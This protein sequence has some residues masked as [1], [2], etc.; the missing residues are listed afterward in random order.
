MNGSS[1]K[2]PSTMFQFNGLASNG[3]QELTYDLSYQPK[4]CC[5]AQSIVAH[6]GE[7]MCKAKQKNSEHIYTID[8]P[9]AITFMKSCGTEGT[10]H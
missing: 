7:S 4:S 10:V 2:S 3:Q 6:V 9:F 1:S 8:S 5:I